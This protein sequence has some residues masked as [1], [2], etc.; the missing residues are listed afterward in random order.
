MKQAMKLYA[1]IKKDQ[2]ILAFILGV[3]LMGLEVGTSLWQNKVSNIV[4]SGLLL[5]GG[6][7]LVGFVS[8]LMDQSRR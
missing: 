8:L 6:W 5:I 7:L 4:N 2:I 3:V 1:L